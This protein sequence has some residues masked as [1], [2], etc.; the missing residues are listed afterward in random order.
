LVTHNG[1]DISNYQPNI[2]AVAMRQAG[3]EFCYVL[4]TDGNGDPSRSGNLTNGYAPQ[5]LSAL[6]AAGIKVGAY[7]FFRPADGTG[8]TNPFMRAYAAC[9][10]FDLPFCIDNETEDP[11]GWQALAAKVQESLVII[12]AG[13]RWPGITYEN[14]NFLRNCP[15][16]P[17]GRG[18][19]LADPSHPTSPSAS[20]LLQQTGTGAVKGVPGLVDLDVFRGTEADWAQFIGGGHVPIPTPPAPTPKEDDIV[21]IVAL[22]ADFNN[23]RH[24]FQM[25]AGGGLW[26]KRQPTNPPGPWVSQQLAPGTNFDPAAGFDALV[27]GGQLHVYPQKPDDHHVAHFWAQEGA[28]TNGLEVFNGPETLP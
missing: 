16:C 10:P 4:L 11:A 2:D 9:G 5:Q 25:S 20:C 17:W 26:H 12:E 13:L 8:Q 21:G 14:L 28:V 27:E 18:L 1:C 24:V 22:E 6:R 7:H 15:G 23:A 19:W 3:I